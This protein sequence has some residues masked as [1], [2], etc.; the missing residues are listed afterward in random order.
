MT[1][2]E[3]Q[4]NSPVTPEAETEPG[5]S[6]MP[7]IEFVGTEEDLGLTGLFNTFRIGTKWAAIETVPGFAEL[8]VT[9]DEECH[10]LD[11]FATVLSVHH[12]TL[13]EMLDLHVGLDHN[14]R[15]QNMA[16]DKRIHLREK[17]ESV[18]GR[19]LGDGEKCVVL[20]MYRDD[21]SATE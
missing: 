9:E 2:D 12:G 17:L 20:Y 10:V 8:V 6:G 14:T 19:K 21:P 7:A 18:Y 11:G 1:E 16:A 5:D 4:D 3:D 15:G 13:G